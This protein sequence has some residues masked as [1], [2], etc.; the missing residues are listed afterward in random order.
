M[1]SDSNA[2]ELKNPTAS[3][4]I[5]KVWIWRIII[6]LAIAAALR[7]V[8]LDSD[9][10]G[11]HSWRQTDTAGVARNMLRGDGNILSPRID[12]RGDGDGR[13]EMEFPLYSWL[14]SSVWRITGIAPW[15]A[16]GISVLASLVTLVLFADLVRR[17]SGERVSI[18][19]AIVA[20]I[21]P[22]AVYYGR[23]AMPESL[24]LC[25]TMSGLYMFWLHLV[26]RSS[27]LLIVSCVLIAG[28]GLVKLPS[29][30]IGLPLVYLVVST[31]GWRAAM[32][33]AYILGAIGVL[34][35][36]AMWYI[37][38]ARIGQETGNSFGVLGS[39]KYGTAAAIA[40]VG[41]WNEIVFRRLGERVF[42][43]IGLPVMLLGLLF[44]RRN[45][46]ERLFDFWM[47]SVFIYLVIAAPGNREHEYYQ[48]PFVLPGSYFA[49]RAI[50][51]WWQ[52]PRL[53]AL[54][55]FLVVGILLLSLYRMNAYW[56][57]ELSNRSAEVALASDTQA[58]STPTDLIIVV[59]PRWSGDPTLLY[60][61][62]RKG[63]V[64]HPSELD[65]I[66][67]KELTDRGAFAIIGLESKFRTDQE[68]VWLTN[69]RSLLASAQAP[70]GTF[71]LRLNSEP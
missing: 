41:F 13:V 18:A 8:H 51:D 16:R 6:V 71:I 62:D 19:S 14:V 66:G 44:A 48:L 30:Y 52:S 60:L 67:I 32:S 45:G 68:R 36:N 57:L 4:A 28:A 1:D 59:S 34:G 9:F 21:A 47:I 7:V 29:L 46:Q 56:R 54:V 27:I 65:T 23:T 5:S 10:I 63:W 11:F 38:A 31:R 50:S 53:R 39:W 58:L 69:L 43:W 64:L 15:A 26:R 37:H 2:H 35:V 61:A 70:E 42:T 24:M 40:D 12:W 55:P 17:I 49:G 33:P 22:L 3:A 20:A 25:L